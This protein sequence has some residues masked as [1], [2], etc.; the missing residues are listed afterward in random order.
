M[1]TIF[2]FIPGW[3]ENLFHQ[4]L[5]D[6]SIIRASFSEEDGVVVTFL[7]PRKRK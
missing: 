2:V 3:N 4:R 6:H 7:A 1:L 5:E